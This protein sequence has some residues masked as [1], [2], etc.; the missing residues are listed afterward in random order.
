MQH[1][2]FSFNGDLLPV[3]QATVHV[4]DIEYAY[5]FGVYETIRTDR[6]VAFFMDEHCDR[7]M[8]SA[9][10]IGLEHTLTKANVAKYV[11]DLIDSTDGKTYNLKLLLIGGATAKDAKLYI[12]CLNPFFPDR[13]LYKTGA[14][15]ITRHF[16]R[17]YPHAK[18]LNMLQSYMAYRDAKK[19]GAYDALLINR[20]GHITEGTRTNFFCINGKTIFT[21]NEDEI[22]LGV[23]RRLILRLAKEDGFEIVEKDIALSSIG[24]YEGAFVT[25]T[26]TKIIPVQSI[27]DH[28]MAPPSDGLKSLMAHCSH[29]FAEYDGRQS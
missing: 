26:S 22:L 16:E 4:S 6:G 10:I 2:L 27:D 20:D 19:C 21:P 18:S 7:L 29:F 25:S 28:I 11:Q 17:P 15:F 13:H 23:M 3:D 1:H 5:G 12:L 24:D 8:E 9:R 14:K